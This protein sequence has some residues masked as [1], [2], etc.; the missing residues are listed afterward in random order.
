MI[1]IDKLAY[2]SPIRK[3]SPVLKSGFAVGSLLVCVG[4]R[5]FIVS[6]FVL[7]LMGYLTVHAGKV[8]LPTY[9]N[10]ILAPATFLLLGTLAILFDITHNPLDLVSIPI[11]N[12]YL[13]ISKANLIETLRLIIVAISSV[14]CLY[15]LSSTTPM[16]DLIY[17]LKRLHMP[18][19]ITE[20]MMLIYRFIFV[21][22]DISA[23][24][25]LSQESRLSTISK[26]THIKAIG[27][28]LSVLLVRAV[29]KAN[30]LY[31][32]ME[33]RCYDGR[34]EVLEE[35]AHSTNKQQAALGLYLI[36]LVSLAVCARLWIEAGI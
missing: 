32:A 8:S 20:L 1:L 10:M 31:D 19:L 26:K 2:T 36:A 9:R 3:Y 29:S 7:I 24:I 22:G 6:V 30:I 27:L 23:A 33:S 15:F 5:S 34:I 28:M 13:S 11:G 25:M 16:L 17:V 4:A 18:W 21:L 14:S 35:A 12:V